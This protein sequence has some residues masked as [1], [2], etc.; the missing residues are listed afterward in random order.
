MSLW[1]KEIFS[2]NLDTPF[3][4]MNLAAQE[5]EKGIPTLSAC[6]L[7]ETV[8]G[9][10]VLKFLVKNSSRAIESVL[11]E[12][13]HRPSLPYPASIDPLADDDLPDYLLRERPI[14]RPRMTSDAAGRLPT[15]QIHT[16]KNEWI[17]ASPNEFTAKL[18]KLLATDSLQIKILGLQMS[19]SPHPLAASDDDD[20][21]ETVPAGSRKGTRRPDN[22]AR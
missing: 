10:N 18:K 7:E 8:M 21:I 6:V 13:S 12:V 3:D 14:K 2:R 15:D 1:P 16:T 4:I 19:A 20:A 5:L 22:R 17:C 11:F 9:Q